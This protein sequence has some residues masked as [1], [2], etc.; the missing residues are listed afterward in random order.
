MSINNI[1]NH[2]KLQ[3]NQK[4][5]E[6]LWSGSMWYEMDEKSAKKGKWNEFVLLGWIFTIKWTQ[7]ILFTWKDDGQSKMG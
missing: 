5:M 7:I 4:R 3:W 1:N 2:S 6:M